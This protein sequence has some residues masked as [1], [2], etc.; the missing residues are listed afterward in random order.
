MKK[1]VTEDPEQL[2]VILKN[3]L[4][5]TKDFSVLKLIGISEA[6]ST[7]NGRMVYFP[8]YQCP[9]CNL[10][11]T[12]INGIPDKRIV[13][14]GVLDYV[15]ISRSQDEIRYTEYLAASITTYGGGKC[16]VYG[17][18]KPD[19]CRECHNKILAKVIIPYKTKKRKN[20]TYPVK[21]CKKCGIYY[22][23]YGIY[24][25]HQDTWELLNP[26]EVLQIGAE[27]REKARLK[28]ERRAQAEAEAAEKRLQ[29]KIDA[30]SVGQ[31]KNENKSLD[32]HNNKQQTE[33]KQAAQ[34]AIHVH[35]NNIRVKDFVVRRNTFKCR[36]N[37]HKLQN[38][39]AL[40]N[41]IDRNGEIKQE[42]VS[43]GYCPKCNIFFI[44]ESIYQSLKIK[45]TPICRVSDEKAY[46]SNN[47]YANGMKLAQESVLRQYGYSVSQE[48]GLTSATRRKILALLVDNKVL[49]KNDIISY[50]D[51]FISQRQYNHKFEKAIDKWE[52]DRE[53]ISE[54]KAGDYATYGVGGIY[55]R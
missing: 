48:E 8:K 29:K 39:N 46:L 50:L 53:F 51:F 55:R 6:I 52:S 4:H 5:C 17:E 54:Y 19:Q 2:Q 40:I 11:Y 33:K 27:L 3:P 21:Y 32:Q 13:P 31:K 35:D 34:E 41:I 12:S 20:A 22:M 49:T 7:S 23:A 44:L 15:N 10:K 45:G 9:K 14:L 42:K 28:A 37:D 47:S 30:Q 18:T 36:Y 38:I 16:Y 25:N 43:A 1:T 26:D 24:S